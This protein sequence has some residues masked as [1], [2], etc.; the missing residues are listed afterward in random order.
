MSKPGSGPPLY[1]IISGPHLLFTGSNGKKCHGIELES[2]ATP[3]QCRRSGVMHRWKLNVNSLRG[4][5][6]PE[7]AGITEEERQQIVQELERMDAE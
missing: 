3:E 7:Y 6:F 2:L 4:E 1:K 5:D